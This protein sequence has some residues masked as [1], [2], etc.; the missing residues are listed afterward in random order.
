MAA[1]T[2]FVA[3]EALNDFDQIDSAKELKR[4]KK[5]NEEQRQ[6]ILKLERQLYL[7]TQEQEQTKAENI[8]LTLEEEK[9]NKI[10]IGLQAQNEHLSAVNEQITIENEVLKTKLG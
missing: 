9:Q 1:M 2:E 7:K 4:Q 5:V 3:G 10:F 6:M 8:S